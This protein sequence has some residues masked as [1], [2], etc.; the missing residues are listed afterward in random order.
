MYTVRVQQ[1]SNISNSKIIMNCFSLYR[2]LWKSICFVLLV[3]VAIVG[4]FGAV[5]FDVRRR[6]NTVYPLDESQSILF[7]GASNVGCAIEETTEYHN[8]VLWVSAS[9]IQSS[10]A[11]LREYEL[12]GYI[13]KVETLL[14]PFNADVVIRYQTRQAFDKAWYKEL[15]LLCT[16]FDLFQDDFISFL[17]YVSD[18]M[19]FPIPLQISEIPPSNRPP[20]SS[21]DHKWR[22]AFFKFCMDDANTLETIVKYDLKSGW[23]E[24]LLCAFKEMKDFCDRNNVRFVVFRMPMFPL[25]EKSIPASVRVKLLEIVERIREFGIEFCDT[26]AMYSE[27]EMFDEDHFVEKGAHRF[28]RDLYDAVKLK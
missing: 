21:R 6:I 9:T 28:T 25:Y 27:D 23:D 3:I 15:P 20:I 18:N 24:A 19:R 16:H 2:F 7:L 14:V 22:T 13:K 10:V 1:P 26:H 8:K 4:T 17:E 12:R 11:R 5:I